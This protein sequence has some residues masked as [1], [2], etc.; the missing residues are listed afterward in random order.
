MGNRRGFERDFHRGQAM[1]WL[2]DLER[3]EPFRPFG[4]QFDA[5]DHGLRGTVTR[6]VHEAVNVIVGSFEDGLDP[7]VGKVTNPAAHPVPEGHPLACIA[8]ED[9][10]NLAGDQYPVADHRQTLPAR[11]A[12]GSMATVLSGFPHP[13]GPPGSTSSGSPPRVVLLQ[14]VTSLDLDGKHVKSPNYRTAL[15]AKHFGL[16]ASVAN[17]LASFPVGKISDALIS[18]GGRFVATVISTLASLGKNPTVAS[19]VNAIQSTAQ[20]IANALKLTVVDWVQQITTTID[21]SLVPSVDNTGTK[22]APLVFL[23]DPVVTTTPAS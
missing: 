23:E 13:R 2:P 18:A 6:P 11:R 4:S 10:L 15:A 19:I 14:I 12:D 7:A 8:E 5:S 20:K 17:W 16:P 21:S 3:A 9:A 22:I 1:T